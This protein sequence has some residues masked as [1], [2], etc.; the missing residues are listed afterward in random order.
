LFAGFCGARWKGRPDKREKREIERELNDFLTHPSPPPLFPTYA[1]QFK[2]RPAF[3]GRNGKMIRKSIAKLGK[4][5][6][7]NAEY[8]REKLPD[9]LWDLGKIYD[10]KVYHSKQSASAFLS[11]LRARHHP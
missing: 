1:F 10:F 3:F 9:T 2:L 11:L 4:L 8:D 6:G 5:S 7:P